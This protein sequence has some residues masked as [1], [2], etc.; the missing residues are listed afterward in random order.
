MTL[1]SPWHSIQACRRRASF[2]IGANLGGY[3]KKVLGYSPIAYWPLY[4][5][6]GVVAECLV[7][8]AQNGTATGVTW[9][10][11]ATGPFG[12]PAPYF[13]GANDYVNIYS[14][15]FNT[16]LNRDSGTIHL[17][18]FA[19]NWANVATRYAVNL[20]IDANNWLDIRKN[21]ANAIRF[22]AKC[23]GAFNSYNYAVPAG[24]RSIWLP[25]AMTWNWGGVNTEV[26][27]YVRTDLKN[28]FNCAGQ[29]TGNLSNTGTVIGA[30]STGPGSVFS[31]WEAHTAV[32]DRVLAQPAIT[33]LANP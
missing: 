30:S 16:A 23:N 3:T 25:I 6:S 11:D 24:E 7:N 13:D 32:W 27:C 4:E 21:G 28:T 17:W 10:N 20:S 26:K 15:V 22:T 14:A 33:D 29:L 5:T 2:T 31:G 19:D 18:M 8:T 9:A 1:K 12:T